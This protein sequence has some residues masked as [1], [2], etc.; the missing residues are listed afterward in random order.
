M[1]ALMNNFVGDGNGYIGNPDLEPEVANTFSVTGGWHDA[2][3]EAWGLKAT[4]YLTRVED[5]ID[6]RRCDFGQCS[7]ANVTKTTG[8]VLLQYANQ[9]ARLYGLDV[10]GHRLLGR[11]AD[12]GTFT[13]KGLLNYVRGENLSTGDNLYHIMP[14]NAKVALVQSL[15]GWT[16]TAEVQWVA[17]KTKVSRVRN[18]VPTDGYGLLNLRTSY[19]WKHARLDIGVENVFDR[20]YSLP[21][22]GAYVG[23]GASMSTSTLPWGI[24]VPGRGR[25]IEVALNAHF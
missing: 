7:A 12:Y 2:G 8:F 18:E 3:R 11:A 10:S 5:F 25:S 4:G 14:L 23:Q 9:S 20:F 6:A 16:H 13:V 24:T 17:A 1:A 19:A 15:G 22:G 21:L